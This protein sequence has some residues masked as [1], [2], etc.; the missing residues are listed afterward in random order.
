MPAACTLPLIALAGPTA[1][2]KTG[3]A[4]ALAHWL[5]ARGQAAEIISVDSALVYRGMDIG[6]AK[7]TLAER[8][9]VP[10]HLLDMR[11]PLH[12][13]SAADFTRDATALMAD[14]RA[15]GALPLL[16]GG[17]MLYFKALAEGLHH[18][19]AA[20]QDIRRQIEAE[21][22]ERGWPALHAELAR[23][24]A[25]TAARLAPADSQ[26]IQRATTRSE[27]RRVGKECR[28]RWSPYH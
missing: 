5:A 18:M 1:S 16:A 28:S 27:E 2:G 14:I 11:D 7:P 26:H 4:V 9:G 20:Q 24:D 17:T 12:A 3:V 10:H 21:A 8:G 23:V 13:Y 25:A 22:A 19:P 15:R 6:T